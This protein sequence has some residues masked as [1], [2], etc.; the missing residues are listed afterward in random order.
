MH[1]PLAACGR[2]V[3]LIF[4]V[5]TMAAGPGIAIAGAGQ[6]AAVRHCQPAGSLVRVQ[7]LPEGSG[8]AASRRLQGRLWAHNDSGR[9]EL[10]ALDTRGAVVGRVR[11]T[12]A[13]IDDWEA[14]AVGPCQAGSCI[15]I[16]DIG[17]NNA[18][19]PQITV[20]RIPE[21]SEA[22]GSVAVADVLHARYPDGA[23]DAEALLATASG[24]LFVVTKGETGAV[25]LYRFPRDARPGAAAQLQRVG[26]PSGS[27]QRTR[28]ERITDGAVSPDGAWVAL[29]TT[30]AV[31]FYR[32][33]E[34][35]AGQWREAGRTS[36]DALREPQGEGITF[37]DDK[38]LYLV[39][40]GGGQSP[41]GTFGRLTCTS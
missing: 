25:A 17:D 32:A 19:R 30:T 37:G 3:Q 34:L 31:V 2:A 7:D 18:N 39:G 10:V 11:V 8:V 21:P 28:G 26:K 29:R 5:S 33:G 38:T 41:A 4:A 36:L 27:D 9:P 24:E 12:G 35:L 16:G 23:H 14:I 15:Y 1:Q 13:T 20:Y 6:A 22:G 40:E